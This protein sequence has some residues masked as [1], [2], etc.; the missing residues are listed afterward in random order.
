MDIFNLPI[1]EQRAA[2]QR[3]RHASLTQALTHAQHEIQLL[4]AA[5]EARQ[6]VT[7]HARMTPAEIHLR[8]FEQARAARGMARG[9]EHIGY[10]TRAQQWRDIASD[11]ERAATILTSAAT[12]Q[13]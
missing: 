13:G 6:A 9:L 11:F 8:A 12:R 5:L 3:E 10:H 1:S 7:P 4:R 2:I